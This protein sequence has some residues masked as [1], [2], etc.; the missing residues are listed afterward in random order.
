MEGAW[1]AKLRAGIALND[2]NVFFMQ[3]LEIYDGDKTQGASQQVFLCEVCPQHAHIWSV[4]KLPS[5][6]QGQDLA[7]PSH[8][9]K[10]QRLLTRSSSL[11]NHAYTPF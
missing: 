1:R 7:P 5:R 4:T 9:D 10:V 3:S 11:V 2:L 8:I 6:V